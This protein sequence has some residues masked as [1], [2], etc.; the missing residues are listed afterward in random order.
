MAK[1]KSRAVR[2][3]RS[4]AP[5]KGK[6]EPAWVRFTFYIVTVLIFIVLVYYGMLYNSKSIS[7]PLDLADSS[8]VFSLLLPFIVFS[9]LL[10]RGNSLEEIIEQLGLS[11]KSLSKSVIVAGI[12]LLIAVIALEAG[13]AVFSTV[14]NIQLPTNVQAVL[15]GTPAYFLIFTFLIAPI[16]EEIF[17]RGFIVTKLKGFT[18]NAWI[19][20]IG[21]AIIFA[22]LHLS[23][24]SVSEFLAAFV[25]GILA[26][27]VFLRMKSLYPS[28]MAHMLVNLLTVISIVSVGLLIHF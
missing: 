18:H 10:L 22:I 14:T 21:G 4:A 8:M 28:I 17:F 19:A 2:K 1:A 7:A 15:A 12:L 13:I 20:I 16:D 26:G 24:L 27:Y 5:R 11:R 9:Y 23:Y 25:F 6:G 3:R